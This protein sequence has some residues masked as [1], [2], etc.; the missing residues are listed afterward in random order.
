MPSTLASI[1]VPTLSI[2]RTDDRDFPVEDSRSTAARIL[3]ATFVELPGNVHFPW[4]G[5]Q[6]AILDE[7]ER[8]VVGLEDRG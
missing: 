4:V 5:E 6:E 3:G 2:A 1:H 8:F 7:V